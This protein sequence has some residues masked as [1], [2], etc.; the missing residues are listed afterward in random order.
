MTANYQLRLYDTNGGQIAV[1]DDWNSVYYFKNLNGTS[2]HTISIPGDD[3]R[4]A[5]FKLDCMIEI[6]RARLADN[7]PWTREYI[8]FHR[9]FQDQV[10]DR[11]D[12]LFTSYGRSFED[13]LKRRSI[14]YPSGGAQD[15][16]S[17]PAD[18]VVKAIV[19][20]NVG[21]NATIANGRI[22][23]GVTLGF[24]VD[25][26]ASQA[27]TWSGSVAFKNV[28][29]A[30]QQIVKAIPF[31]FLVDYPSPLAFRFQTRYPRLGTDRTGAGSA[32][33]HIFSLGHANMSSPYAV[34]SHVDEGNVVLV[35]GPGE[36]A[37]RTFVERNDPIAML[38]SPW[39]SVEKT[40]DARTV[41]TT[42]GLNAIGDAQLKSLAA[43]R[44]I[45][46]QVLESAGSVYGRDY[47]LGD[48]VLCQFAG[49][50]TVKKIAGVE[51]T[52]ANGREDIRI[53][54]DDEGLP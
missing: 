21:L 40:I 44:R 32:A 3:S 48:L 29:D 27:P 20:E 16:K 33:P 38:R 8:G 43:T 36:A 4:R 50:Q 5:L 52:V 22:R 2:V 35:L 11:G 14:L 34:E 51:I 45:S 49:F 28:L 1:F 24:A 12:V 47:F 53:H 6:R 18:D 13:L 17:G 19:R 42:P 41:T 10:T 30:L 26:N 46:F 23:D 39:G 54:F 9:T 31:D 15:T 37:A 25:V 7:I